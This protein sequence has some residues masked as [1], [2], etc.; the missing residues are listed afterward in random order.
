MPAIWLARYLWVPANQWCGG[1]LQ[2]VRSFRMRFNLRFRRGVRGRVVPFTRG[3]DRKTKPLLA[4]SAT[5]GVAV[6]L[7]AAV[8][9]LS[10]AASSATGFRPAVEWSAHMCLAGEFC[11]VGDVNGDGRA[12]AIA[13]TQGGNPNGGPP[14]SVFVALSTGK[15]F[16]AATEWAPHMCLA[17][18]HCAIADVNGDGLADAIAFT[19]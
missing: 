19:Q 10:A 11:A 8:P 9:G 12:D 16:A 3:E 1:A 6:A 17:G 18:E 14:G 7:L 2:T 13:F 4:L 15:K 5:V